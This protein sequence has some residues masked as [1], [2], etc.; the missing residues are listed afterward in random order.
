MDFCLAAL[1]VLHGNEVV[2]SL[3]RYAAF[4]K[5]RVRGARQRFRPTLT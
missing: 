5:D 4:S 1:A 2:S 3:N